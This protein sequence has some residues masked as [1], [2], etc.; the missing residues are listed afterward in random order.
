VITAISV[1]HPAS[2]RRARIEAAIPNA[3][4]A[5]LLERL[6]ERDGILVSNG[7]SNRADIV[8]VVI[9]HLLLPARR[10]R[11][12]AMVE[13]GRDQRDHSQ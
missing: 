8:G 10:R 11:R 7:A 3:A 2:A 1:A 12:V 13:D 4:K 9:L 6:R 5:L